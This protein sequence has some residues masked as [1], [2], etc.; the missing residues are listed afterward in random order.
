MNRGTLF[1]ALGIFLAALIMLAGYLV[2]K[3]LLKDSE[4]REAESKWAVSEISGSIEGERV[5][6]TP[7]PVPSAEPTEGVI[8]GRS[9]VTELW[10]VF[11][12]LNRAQEM[13]PREPRDG[14]LRMGAAVAAGMEQLDV[15]FGMEGFPRTDTFAFSLAYAE[16][17][18][19]VSY[20]DHESEIGGDSFAVWSLSF[21]EPH[22]NSS[23]LVVIDARDATVYSL[24]FYSDIF[25]YSGTYFEMLVSYANYLGI[26]ESD[27]FTASYS[28]YYYSAVFSGIRLSVSSSPREGAIAFSLSADAEFADP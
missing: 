2:P 17:T 18:D 28:G 14:E 12:R 1:N 21:V 4:R 9:R 16:L 5:S 22:T 19:P 7:T 15:L 23:I 11:S 3:K 13:T 27:E 10:S 24:S 8:G 26:Y 25:D 6:S 20:S